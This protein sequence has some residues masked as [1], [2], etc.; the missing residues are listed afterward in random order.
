MVTGRGKAIGSIVAVLAAVTAV[1]PAASGEAASPSGA[2]TEREA[3]IVIDAT[4]HSVD[5]SSPA[6][7]A[8]MEEVHAGFDDG[9]SRWVSEPVLSWPQAAAVNSGFSVTFDATHTAPADVQSIVLAAAANWDNA[10]ATTAAGPVEIAVIWRDMGSPSLLGSAG[11]NGLYASGSLPTNSFY[12]APLANTLLGTDVNGSATPELT[13][14]LNSTQNWYVGTGAPGG[15]QIDLYSVVLHEI[16]H[17]LGFLGSGSVNNDPGPDPTL[18]DPSFVFDRAVTHGGTPLLSTANPDSLLES[19]NLHI[20]ISNGLDEKLYAPPSWQEGSSFSHF[21]EGSSPAGT[22]G[23]L[24]TPSIASAQTER[25]LDASVLGVMEGMG[26]PM[27]VDAVTPTITDVDAGGSDITVAW[28]TDLTQTGLAPDGYRI[29]AWRNGVTLDGLANVA[30]PQ[31]TATITSLQGGNSYTVLVVPIADGVDGDAAT[32]EVS[33]DGAPPAPGLVTAT[34]GGLTQTISWSAPP[35]DGITSYSVQISQDG[36]SWT[37]VGTTAGT[38]LVTTVSEGVHQ[39][40]V[41]ATNGYGPGAFGYTI[42]TGVSAGPVRPVALDG[43][44]AR[45]YHAYFLREPDA[46]GF[47]YWRGQRAGR[48]PLGSISGTFATGEEFEASYGPLSDAEFVELVYQNVLDR[49]SDPAG[50]DYWTGQ[51]AAGVGRGTVMAGFSESA[52]FIAKTGSVAP[53]STVEDEVYRLYVAF[54][55]RF[56]DP[57]GFDYWVGVRNGGSS[58][59]SIAAS[60]AGS[61]EFV[62]TYGSLPDD[63]FVEL[64]Y[65]NVLGRV[66]DGAGAAYWQGQLA[67][68]LD[69]GAMMVGFSESAEFV[70][71]TGTLP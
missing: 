52:E 57:A 32:T 54:F 18:D 51:L 53:R 4:D 22:S 8:E 45:L 27:R 12:P 17:G 3:P 61:T 50:R 11:P 31:T 60:F 44:I 21:D 14:N 24:M 20:Q 25:S 16:G 37:T 58:L 56:P 70:V 68:G 47:D 66:P 35:A 30:S 55:R 42:P 13:V 71:S 6:L 43:Q 39:F 28:Q 63:R 62:Q 5:V 29:E 46:A 9:V 10:L 7:I 59:E 19:D 15:G 48:V 38:S 34:G 36:T 69:R 23:A 1:P 26:W 49:P 65:N 33:L 41:R 2:V 67:A 64:V 40:R